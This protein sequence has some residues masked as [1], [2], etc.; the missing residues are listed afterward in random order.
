MHKLGSQIILS[1]NFW[2]HKNNEIT[3]AK[4]PW[5]WMKKR[6]WNIFEFWKMVTSRWL[7]EDVV[8]C[9]WR[10]LACFD[11]RFGEDGVEIW[12]ADGWDGELECISELE[13]RIENVSALGEWKASASVSNSL[14]IFWFKWDFLSSIL[15]LLLSLSTSSPFLSPFSSP[16]LIRLLSWLILWLLK[17]LR[18]KQMLTT[19]FEALSRT[20]ANIKH[21]RPWLWVLMCS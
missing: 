16:L 6:C 13:W 15:P 2:I 7:E 3:N 14:D 12:K 4:L 20:V 19:F 10:R 21:A 17:L 1:N 5:K 18:K 8:M 9:C 11:C